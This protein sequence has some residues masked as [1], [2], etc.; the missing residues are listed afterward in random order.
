M[1]ISHYICNN[2]EAQALDLTSS[3]GKLCCQWCDESDQNTLRESRSTVIVPIMRCYATGDRTVYCLPP[4][5]R[6]RRGAAPR[7]TLPLLHNVRTMCNRLVR[8]V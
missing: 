4:T 2:T 8:T 1:E 3:C 5:A 7:V 6:T